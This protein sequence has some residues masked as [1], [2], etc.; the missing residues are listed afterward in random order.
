MNYVLILSTQP[1]VEAFQVYLQN[2]VNPKQLNQFL[3]SALLYLT[4][5][6]SV[7]LRSG[8]L[9]LNSQRSRHPTGIYHKLLLA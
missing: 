8:I 6:S 2:R 9:R 3:F 4:I 7:P 1:I 5:W